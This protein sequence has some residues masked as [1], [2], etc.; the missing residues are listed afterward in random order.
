MTIHQAKGLEFKRVI[1]P[2]LN[3]GILPHINSMEQLINLEEERRLMYVAMSRAMERLI[4]TYNLQETTDG[5]SDYGGVEVLEGVGMRRGGMIGYRNHQV[6]IEWT[7][8]HL[9]PT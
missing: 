9:A 3:E 1:V 2:G 5:A 6:V 4:I 8:L 7:A